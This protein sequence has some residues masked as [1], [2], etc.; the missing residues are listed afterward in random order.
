MCRKIAGSTWNYN[1]PGMG[2][3]RSFGKRQT[4]REGSGDW[5]PD[6]GDRPPAGPPLLLLAL[7]AHPAAPRCG[8]LFNRRQPP[9]HQAPRSAQGRSGADRG[10]RQ[11]G[12]RH[13]RG[14]G[15]RGRAVSLAH[16]V[17]EQGLY[18]FTALGRFL[19]EIGS[20]RRSLARAEPSRSG[21][22]RRGGRCSI[23]RGFLPSHRQ[24]FP[25]LGTNRRPGRNS[26]GWA[27][28]IFLTA[29]QP[30]SLPAALCL[31]LARQQQSCGR[32]PPALAR[33]R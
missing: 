25:Y 3:P 16:V 6:S 2:H 10:G 14:R 7:P 26:V 24:E 1:I 11:L 4:S 15:N 21:R 18:F 8:R 33:D 12:R 23:T 5:R 20:F 9:V 29:W 31:W 30:R 19:G 28:E 32:P 22:G 13:P 27:E 17:F